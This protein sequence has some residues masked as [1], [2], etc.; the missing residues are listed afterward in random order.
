MLASAILKTFRPLDAAYS[1]KVL[2]R[3]IGGK[4]GVEIT[5]CSGIIIVTSLIFLKSTLGNSL[6]SLLVIAVNNWVILSGLKFN[7]IIPSF[8]F[9]L[10]SSINL[11]GTIN[12]SITPFS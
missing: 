8:S 10:P 5:V 4:A 9:K 11:A 2:V 7:I 12:S 6:N 1:P 3:C